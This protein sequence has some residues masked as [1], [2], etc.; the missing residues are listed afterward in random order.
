MPVVIFLGY[1]YNSVTYQNDQ[2]LN[3]KFKISVFLLYDITLAQ[4]QT[5]LSCTKIA[6]NGIK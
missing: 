1:C 4:V 5:S 3:V 2:R 6:M